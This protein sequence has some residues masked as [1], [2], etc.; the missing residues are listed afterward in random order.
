MED[1]RYPQYSYRGRIPRWKFL[2]IP[3]INSEDV[4]LGGSFWVSPMRDLFL[5]GKTIKVSDLLTFI[6]SRG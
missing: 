3:N 2:G 4:F 1:F 6:A 5:G